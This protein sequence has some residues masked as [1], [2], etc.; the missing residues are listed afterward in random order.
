L[1]RGGSPSAFDRLLGTRFGVA[2]AQLCI[3][4]QSGRM[5]ALRG[6]RI[7]HVSLDEALGQNKLVPVDGE[8][9]AAARA[10]GIEMGA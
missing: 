4:G 2:A 3:K 1:Q 9:V 7:I 8:L 10:I 6:Q 5:V